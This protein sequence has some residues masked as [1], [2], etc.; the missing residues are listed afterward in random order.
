MSLTIHKPSSDVLKQ[1]VRL[2]QKI[3][4]AKL[5]REGFERKLTLW[6]PLVSGCCRSCWL[7][8]HSRRRCKQALQPSPSLQPGALCSIAGDRKRKTNWAVKRST[9]R[10][11]IS[12]LDMSWGMINLW[13]VHLREKA[14]L[15]VCCRRTRS[16]LCSSFTH[17]QKN[18][19]KL[20]LLI[21]CAAVLTQ[22]ET[23]AGT[24]RVLSPCGNT[25]NNVHY[26][27]CV[28]EW[29]YTGWTCT[30][31]A[32]S[33]HPWLPIY[34][35]AWMRKLQVPGGGCS[36]LPT[37]LLTLL[38]VK[39]R[40]INWNEVTYSTVHVTPVDL[41]EPFW[42]LTAPQL[43][44]ISWCEVS[45]NMRQLPLFRP[46]SIS[47]SQQEISVKYDYISCWIVWVVMTWVTCSD[48]VSGTFSESSYTVQYVLT[49]LHILASKW[50]ETPWNSIKTMIYYNKAWKNQYN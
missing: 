8:P 50:R 29:T 36:S 19:L 28:R 33:I 16:P 24:V 38:A 9:A 32:Y 44:I 42:A 45:A 46:V 43:L 21:Q 12:H 18:T 41:I 2:E 27:L 14:A 49:V 5:W 48:T 47:S 39:Y 35:T 37:R 40:S 15:W 4:E 26:I 13:L 30:I 20:L 3:P 23:R 25:T 22:D 31:Q 11:A 10:S 6:D 34:Y 7:H 17:S 1:V